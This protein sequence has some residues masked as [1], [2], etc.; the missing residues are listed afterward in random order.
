[1]PAVAPPEQKKNRAHDIGDPAFRRLARSEWQLFVKDHRQRDITSGRDQSRE[2]TQSEV[3]GKRRQNDEEEITQNSCA[4]E[5][6]IGPHD[7][8]ERS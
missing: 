6:D 1:M 4:G 2:N 5:R 8:R 7:K 3:E